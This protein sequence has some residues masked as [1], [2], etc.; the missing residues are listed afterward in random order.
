MQLKIYKKN[1]L[2]LSIL[3]LLNVLGVVFLFLTKDQWVEKKTLVI[4]LFSLA[5][6]LL[7]LI[8]SYI[9]LYSDKNIIR[10]CLRNGNVALAKI[11]KGGFVRFARDVKFRNYAY[12]KLEVDLYDN[13]MKKIKTEIIE[14]FNSHQTSIPSGYVFVTYEDGKPDEC[15]IIPNAIIASVPEYKPLVEEYEKAIKPKYL[16]VYYYQGLVMQTFEDAIKKQKEQ[17]KLDEEFEERYA[18]EMAEKER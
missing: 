15:L 4:T 12:W 10:K 7:S 11:N 9:E 1:S 8:Y 3:L 5:I 2:F 17:K 18:K 13:D 16:S 14:K 6:L